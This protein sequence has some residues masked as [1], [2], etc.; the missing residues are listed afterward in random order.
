MHEFSSIVLFEEP[1]KQIRNLKALPEVLCTL[2]FRINKKVLQPKALFP[3]LQQ[4][5]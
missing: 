1:R 4:V 2:T 5:P 3:L